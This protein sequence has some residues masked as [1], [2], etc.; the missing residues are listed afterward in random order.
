MKKLVVVMLICINF[1]SYAQNYFDSIA[2]MQTTQINNKIK[3]ITIDTKSDSIINL[4]VFID[5]PP[6]ITKYYPEEIDFIANLKYFKTQ[7]PNLFYFRLIS[8]TSA[9]DSVVAFA[10]QK[11]FSLT[12]ETSNINT[13]IER[14]KFEMTNADQWQSTQYFCQ[15]IAFD[16]NNY[17]GL[18]K[19]SNYQALNASNISLTYNSF[20]ATCTITFV[21]IGK[22]DQDTII[23]TIERY[24]GEFTNKQTIPDDP[25]AQF[26][27]ANNKAISV[28]ND[29]KYEMF[30]ILCKTDLKM[31]DTNY[32]A[33]QIV[34]NYLIDQF[35]YIGSELKTAFKS[36][37]YTNPE[38]NFFS[39][40][41][42]FGSVPLFD[43]IINLNNIIINTKDYGLSQN[44]FD[45]QKKYLINN[46]LELSKNLEIPA[47]YCFYTEK[48]QLPK[49]Y[50]SNLYT[51]IHNVSLNSVNNIAQ[52]INFDNIQFLLIYPYYKSICELLEIARFFRIDFYDTKLNKYKIIPQGFSAL[53]VQKDYLDKCKANSQIENLTVEFKSFYDLDSGYVLWGT[54]LKKKN[55]MY[56]FKSSLIAG[57]DTLFHQLKLLN[58][59]YCIDSNAISCV[60]IEDKKV[61]WQDIQKNSFFPEL[62]Y[63]IEQYNAQIL[64][65]T[66]LL[67]EN[68]YKIR[69]NTPYGYHFIDYYNYNTKLK[70]R[71]EIIMPKGIENDTLEII[72]YSNFKNISKTSDVK[73]PFK[74]IQ[75]FPKYTI[76]SEIIR[77]DDRTK[78]RNKNF[79][80]KIKKK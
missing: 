52:N 76:T 38:F 13:F 29:Y 47:L 42:S 34:Y 27:I 57:K 14:K 33:K 48:Y 4:F 63:A 12:F 78:L 30:N 62:F 70:Q 31:S 2:K 77:I 72:E 54:I 18:G 46:Y 75:Y 7:L 66:S 35:N 17:T 22:I 73:F 79:N 65:D 23:S 24:F 55:Q 8:D 39:F 59:R 36:Y 3:L 45:K 26:N 5:F 43:A 41:Y 71:T 9:I 50:F 49:N 11:L 25:I 64:C 80:V 21:A 56:L 60:H 19:I 40:S 74:V 28:I 68:T 15:S 32:F 1:F 44:E 67:K 10:K 69:V 16:K 53:N 61:F 51:K 37:V 58:N 20:L 6:N